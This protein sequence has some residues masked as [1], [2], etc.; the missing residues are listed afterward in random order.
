MLSFLYRLPPRLIF[1]RGRLAELGEHTAPLG[2]RAL[3]VT[4]RQA[5]RAAG[6]TDRAIASLQAAGVET[7]LFEKALPNPTVANAEAGAKLARAEQ[8][9]VV[10]GLGGGSAMD[11]AKAIAVGAT[12][13]EP[14]WDFIIAPPGQEKTPATA[15]TLPI[16]CVPTTAGTASELT[17]FA[18]LTNAETKDKAALFSDYIFA[19]VALSDPELTYSVPPDV[20]A[21]TG[22][23]VFAHAVESYISTV[24]HPITEACTQEAI[25]L[26][27][28]HLRRAVADGSEKEAREQMLIAN[29]LAGFG[30]SNTGANI[31]HALEHPLSAHDDSIAHGGG[32][33]ALMRAYFPFVAEAAPQKV[34]RVAE[35]LGEDVT[36][37]SEADA[38]SRA[39]EALRK[40]IADVGAPARLRDLGVDRAM[41]PTYAED[42]LR[43]MAGALGKCPRPADRED[44]I[45]YLEAAY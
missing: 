44:L 27:A 13:D 38:C 10:V 1:G 7:V 28:L 43:Y 37:L 18:V 30:L 33:S 9:D 25:R 24:A 21:N 20:T 23:D 4:G 40:L 45:R 39:H 11:C 29:T 31:M 5:A 12:H 26:V 3:L 41:F 8:C 22:L 16:V 15:A 6:F 32:L 42:A 36:G 19:R 34:R 35:L 14:L 17:P 2:R